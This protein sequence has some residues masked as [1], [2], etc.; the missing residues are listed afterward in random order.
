VL[1]VAAPFGLRDGLRR[2]ERFFSLTYPA[3]TPH[4]GT[5]GL[6]DVTGLLPAVPGGTGL[7]CG[8]DFFWIL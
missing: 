1:I 2:K 3:L 5:P 4:P 6:G 8:L 7:W